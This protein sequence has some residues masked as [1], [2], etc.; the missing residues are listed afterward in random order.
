MLFAL[1]SAGRG[2]E[3][4]RLSMKTAARPP[5][6]VHINLLHHKK[7]LKSSEFPGT[8][9]IP[10]YPENLNLCPVQCMDWHLAKTAGF[11]VGIN[12]DIPED[13]EDLLFR[14]MSQPFKGI[15]PKT[16]LAG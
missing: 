12:V 10:T 14:S 13:D 6:G 16:F 1:V 5:E 9:F 8:K 4:S 2:T 11:R 15:T 3:T 7:Y